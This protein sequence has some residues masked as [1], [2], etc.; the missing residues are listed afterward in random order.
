MLRH[1]SQSYIQSSKLDSMES[2]LLTAVIDSPIG[3]LAICGSA[4][5]LRR[6]YRTE[7]LEV[8]PEFTEPHPVTDA[9]AQLRAYFSKQRTE[10]DL[11]FDWS[12]H[13][14][15]SVEVWQALLNIPF[16]TTTSYSAIAEQ[17]NQP[18]AVRAVGMANR[19]NPFAI[20]VPCHRVIGKSGD[21]TGYFYG[22]ETKMHLLRHENPV[23]YPKQLSLLGDS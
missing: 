22:L 18:K 13:P 4:L 10:F 8:T 20:V 17:L 15:F 14:D 21:L 5:G 1:Q 16:G 19:N 7:A 6:I 2:P 9:I 11:K 3:H 23:R 12:G